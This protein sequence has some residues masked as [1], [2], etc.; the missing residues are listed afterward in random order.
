[1]GRAFGF[2]RRGDRSWNIGHVKRFAVLGAAVL[3]M[4]ACDAP[5]GD[6]EAAAQ[7]ACP[8]V[9]RAACIESFIRTVE[10]GLPAVLC[11]FPDGQW[12][13][14]TP[15]AG[16]NGDEVGEA[17]GRSRDGTITAVLN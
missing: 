1:M 16:G 15:G 8:T 13:F 14:G 9:E 6:V 12:A 7:A 5:P 2:E 11:V 4:T 3:V 10:I 17:C